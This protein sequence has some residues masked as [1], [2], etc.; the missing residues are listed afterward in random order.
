MDLGY[1]SPG[2]RRV[3]GLTLPGVGTILSNYYQQVLTNQQAAELLNTIIHEAVHYT[4]DINDP[5]QDDNAAIGFPY[6]EANLLTTKSLVKQLNAE[7]KD[8]SCGK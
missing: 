8:C 4:L 5:R 7:R 2:H 1:T 6:S 3:A